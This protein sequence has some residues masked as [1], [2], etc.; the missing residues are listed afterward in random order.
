MTTTKDKLETYYRNKTA[1]A[2]NKVLTTFGVTEIFVKQN[3]DKLTNNRERKI[4]QLRLK[5]TSFTDISREVQ[6]S[7]H[8][9]DRVF[10]SA[11]AKLAERK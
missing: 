2:V 9:V 4:V 3:L 8:S 5:N 1:E 11:I 10:K 7:S 6:I